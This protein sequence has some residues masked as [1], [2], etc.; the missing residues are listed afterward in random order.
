MSQIYLAGPFFSEEQI[1]RVSR[2][3]KALEEN[4]T[5]TSFLLSTS[6]PRK[7]L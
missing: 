3:E 1:D 2:I 5:V 4:K 6:S 7:Q